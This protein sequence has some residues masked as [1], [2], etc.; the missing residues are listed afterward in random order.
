MEEIRYVYCPACE[1]KVRVV[2]TPAP[3]ASDGHA[4]IPDTQNICLDFGALCEAG[5]TASGG[6]AQCPVFG[7]PSLVM[8]VARARAGMTPEPSL[9][10][11]L[12]CP[13]CGLEQ[14][15]ELVGMK[16]AVCSVCG[17]LNALDQEE[18]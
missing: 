5:A 2:A 9:S 6:E 3:S 8:G 11:K 12:L 7:A 15:Q 10:A 17:S 13:A 1:R 14:G 16:H 4:S 18:T